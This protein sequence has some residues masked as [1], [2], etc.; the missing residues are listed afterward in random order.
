SG[1]SNPAIPMSFVPNGASP[2]GRRLLLQNG[3]E[4]IPILGKRPLHDDW[5]LGP[6]T[7]ERLA[8]IEEEHPDHTN[9]GLRTGWLAVGDIDVREPTHAEDVSRTIQAVLG[10][11]C[12][13]RFGSKGIAL[14]Y[15]NDSPIRKIKITGIPQGSTKTE[16]L[17]EFLG[18]GNH[19]AA[20]GIHP[21]T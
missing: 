14:C 7:E 21:D 19:M 11:T 9:T 20:Y 1:N 18:A 13:Q 5:Q 8:K 15:H 2:E 12:F 3:Y 10:E 17:V 4:P 6:I 16:T